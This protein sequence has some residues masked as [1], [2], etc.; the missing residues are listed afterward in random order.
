VRTGSSGSSRRCGALALIGLAALGSPVARADETG[1]YQAIALLEGG[2]AGTSGSLQPRVLILDTVE[3]HLWIWEENVRLEAQ[4]R[5]P[6]F[7]TALVYQGR[8]RPGT[9]IG[10]VIEQSPRP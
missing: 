3:G 9:R 7:G 8:V 6:S 4:G 2:R 1:R 5:P 10:E